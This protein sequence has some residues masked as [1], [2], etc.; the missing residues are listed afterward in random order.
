MKIITTTILLFFSLNA[1]AGLYID[2]Y[3]L[4]SSSFFG[5]VKE[6]KNPSDT[7]MEFDFTGTVVG[8]KLGWASKGNMMMGLDFSRSRSKWVLVAPVAVKDTVTA[9]DNSLTDNWEGYHFGIF[10]GNRLTK[11]V[12]ATVS[13]FLT[14]YRDTNFDSTMTK[15][16][17]LTGFTYS[18]GV[19]YVL[20]GV[21]LGVEWR[22][23]T[24]NSYTAKSNGQTYSLPDTQAD[25][26]EF[27]TQEFYFSISLPITIGRK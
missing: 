10:V 7:N 23:S 20:L 27:R 6:K 26:G 21:K 17:K 1:I 5:Q 12:I 8:A 3:Y 22:G 4:A 11:R 2:P 24:L 15:G 13:A 18:V 9:A 16:D 14:S 25:L 19:G